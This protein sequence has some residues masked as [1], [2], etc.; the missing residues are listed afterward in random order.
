MSYAPPSVYPS[1][2]WISLTTGPGDDAQKAWDTAR[3]LSIEQLAAGNETRPWSANGYVGWGTRHLRFG[4]KGDDCAVELSGE[5]SDRYW[6]EF[7]LLSASISRLDRAVTVQFDHDVRDLAV[8][9]YDAPGVPVAPGRPPITKTLL[10][11]TGGGQTL[12]V[13]AMGGRR[14]GRLYDKHA[15]SRGEFP[16][17][18]WRWEL[19]DR[20]PHSGDVA[21]DLGRADDVRRAIRAGV[22]RFF[23]RNGVQPWFHSDGVAVPGIRRRPRS[24]LSDR[25]AWWG[26]QVAPGVRRGLAGASRAAIADALG[27]NDGYLG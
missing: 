7:A 23:D 14:L 21:C 18:T 19:Q 20:S 12:Y 2:D 8:N 1:I 27:L 5:L 26:S 4:R 25:F 10:R 13:G 9:G 3:A 17:N 15:E 22:H 6:Q 11:G 16:A 24:D